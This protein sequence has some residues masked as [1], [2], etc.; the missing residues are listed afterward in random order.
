MLYTK[1]AVAGIWVGGG[2]GGKPD[3]GRQPLV[4]TARLEGDTF[5]YVR[6]Q[7]ITTSLRGSANT[8]AL[9]HQACG[10]AQCVL[11]GLKNGDEVPSW[12]WAGQ[13]AEV[14]WGLP[15][16]S[17]DFCLVSQR[18]QYPVI[19]VIRFATLRSRNVTAT[20]TRDNGQT[21]GR[22]ESTPQ[23]QGPGFRLRDPQPGLCS[24]FAT[25][26]QGNRQQLYK[27]AGWATSGCFS[28][29]RARSHRHGGA[30][31]AGV[32]GSSPALGPPSR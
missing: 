21:H 24:Q 9:G 32:P 23:R 11:W 28:A 15:H 3:P 22:G 14:D 7:N 16:S 12:P 20:V 13:Q 19:S 4:S 29:R 8:A 17:G 27:K 26:T 31:C 5:V 18:R 10:K 6:F 1:A 30:E 2:G 25:V